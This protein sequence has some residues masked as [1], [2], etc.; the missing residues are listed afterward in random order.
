MPRHKAL[1][2]AQASR[3]RRFIEIAPI[4]R[5]PKAITVA[6]MGNIADL[7][8]SVG[9]NCAAGGTRN[10]AVPALVVLPQL[11]PRRIQWPRQF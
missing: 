8:P 3:R 2:M 7:M 11:N 9:L 10:R 1:A 6:T 5:Q 4:V